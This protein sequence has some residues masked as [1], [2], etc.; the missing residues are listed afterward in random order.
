MFHDSESNRTSEPALGNATLHDLD[1]TGQLASS[2]RCW[3]PG[4]IA[5]APSSSWTTP[6]SPPKIDQ[7]TMLRIILPLK[8]K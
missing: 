3:W 6:Q 2:G 5:P 4:S 7:T 8:K 1:L